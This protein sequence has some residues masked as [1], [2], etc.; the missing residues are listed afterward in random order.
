MDSIKVIAISFGNW[1][2]GLTQIHE[3]LQIVV[4]MLSIILLV[5]NINKGRK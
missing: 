1:A 5:M 4:A 2:I 3:S